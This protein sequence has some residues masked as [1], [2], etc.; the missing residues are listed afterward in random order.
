MWG[1][2]HRVAARLTPGAALLANLPRRD[3]APPDAA[4]ALG[5]AREGLALRA[6]DALPEDG[7]RPPRERLRADA[8]VPAGE[9]DAGAQQ[10]PAQDLDARLQH[11]H[12]TVEDVPAV[13]GAAGED[14][15]GGERAGGEGHGQERVD[16]AHEQHV[17]VEEGDAG[18]AADG[19]S[20][21]EELDDHRAGSVADRALE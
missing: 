21:E 7:G 16:V 1:G 3:A 5:L 13:L 20:E 4:L 12:A 6:P 19:E 15:D 14:V 11:E 9:E 8:L 18:E 2:R 17:E 10:Q